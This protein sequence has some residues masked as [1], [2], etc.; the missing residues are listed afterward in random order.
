MRKPTQVRIALLMLRLNALLPIFSFRH[1]EKRMK[2]TFAKF[3][4]ARYESVKSENPTLKRSQIKEIIW[5]EWQKSPEN[6]MN[7]PK[8]N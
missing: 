8:Q 5:K 4:E 3:E 2:A 6:P 7:Q 1:P